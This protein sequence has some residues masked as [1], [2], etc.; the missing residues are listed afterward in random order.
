MGAAFPLADPSISGQLPGSRVIGNL[1]IHFSGNGVYQALNPISLSAQIRRRLLITSAA[2]T[3]L[4][5][6]KRAGPGAWLRWGMTVL[7]TRLR[8]SLAPMTYLGRSPGG[9]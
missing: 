7:T 3:P 6:L 9:E 4:Q 5:K 2:D 1:K 8:E